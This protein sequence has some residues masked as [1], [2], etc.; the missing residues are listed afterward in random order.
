MSISAFKY[1]LSYTLTCLLLKE[2]Q[3]RFTIFYFWII[4]RR[5]VFTATHLLY[6][7][8]LTLC[9]NISNT[10]LVAQCDYLKICA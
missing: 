9:A 10:S 4:M 8:R 3:K 5:N 2:T 1:F 7:D 6:I